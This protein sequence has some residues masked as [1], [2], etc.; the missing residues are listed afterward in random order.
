M[1][2]LYSWLKDFVDIDVPPEEVAYKLTMAGLEIEEIEG[3]EDSLFLVERF[4]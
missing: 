2:I 3:N 1:K 4:R